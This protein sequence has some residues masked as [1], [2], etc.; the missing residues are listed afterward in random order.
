MNVSFAASYAI[1]IEKCTSKRAIHQVLLKLLLSN[2]SK[3][4]A[5]TANFRLRIGWREVISVE[6]NERLVL[7]PK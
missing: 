4:A 6:S 1:Q 2:Q 3:D 7:T 5:C